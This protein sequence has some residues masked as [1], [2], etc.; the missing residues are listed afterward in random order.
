MTLK[1]YITG[2]SI[3]SNIISIN[4]K[5]EHYFEPNTKRG[6][7]LSYYYPD[8]NLFIEPF[9][10]GNI[11]WFYNYGLYIKGNLDDKFKHL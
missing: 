10:S 2:I 11:K 8:D 7:G 6:I 5:R 9:K 3:D 1:T 4:Y